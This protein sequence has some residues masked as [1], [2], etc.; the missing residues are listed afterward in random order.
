MMLVRLQTVLAS[1]QEVVDR[2][3]G[4][5]ASDAADSVPPSQP[6]E[7]ATLVLLLPLLRLSYSMPWRTYHIHVPS[8]TM[9]RDSSSMLAM[10]SNSRESPA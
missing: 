2:R 1:R 9:A 4:K 6:D 10:P 3:V 8:E 7:T 5:V